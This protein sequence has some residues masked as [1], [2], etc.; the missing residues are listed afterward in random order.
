[1]NSVISSASLL[2]GTLIPEM[3]PACE[4]L[5]DIV[6]NVLPCVLLTYPRRTRGCAN[7]TVF[8]KVLQRPYL[9]L[10]QWLGGYGLMREH[11]AVLYLSARTHKE[12]DE[13]TR[14]LRAV[15]CP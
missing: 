2:S 4:V 6:M 10:A 5:V 12:H 14:D 3:S 13:E 8:A 15:S 11:V 9:K 1:M 7:G